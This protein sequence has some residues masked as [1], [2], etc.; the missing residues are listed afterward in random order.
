MANA[1]EGPKSKSTQVFRWK[2]QQAGR[3]RAEPRVNN[4][5]VSYLYQGEAY[6]VLEI[7]QEKLTWLS[8]DIPVLRIAW[9]GVD[10]KVQLELLDDLADLSA[11]TGVFLQRIHGKPNVQIKFK[12]GV[13]RKVVPVDLFLLGGSGDSELVPLGQIVS[14]EAQSIE[15]PAAFSSRP[16]IVLLFTSSKA[17][18]YRTALELLPISLE[19]PS[20]LVAPVSVEAKVVE[21]SPLVL[22]DKDLDFDISCSKGV[23]LLAFE[24]PSFFASETD[25]PVECEVTKSLHLRFNVDEWRRL[26]GRTLP[27]SGSISYRMSTGEVGKV[28]WQVK[29]YERWSWLDWAKFRVIPWLGLFL[30]GLSA[31]VIGCVVVTRRL[32]RRFD[33]V[34]GKVTSEIISRLSYISEAITS[35]SFSVGSIKS[36]LETWRRSQSPS[37]DETELRRGKLDLEQR[38]AQSRENEELSQQRVKVL[39]RNV[40]SLEQERQSLVEKYEAEFA[41]VNETRLNGEERIKQFAR[42]LEYYEKHVIFVSEDTTPLLDDLR[43]QMAEFVS[44]AVKLQRAFEEVVFTSSGSLLAIRQLAD[45]YI[46]S[47]PLDRVQTYITYIAELS[48]ERRSVFPDLVGRVGAGRKLSADDCRRKICELFYHS[49]IADRWDRVLRGLQRFYHIDKV[50]DLN[51]GDSEAHKQFVN[52]VKL[53]AAGAENALR[54]IDVVPLAISFLDRVGERVSPFV[55]Y[56]PEQPIEEYYPGW[57]ETRVDRR[58]LVLDAHSWGYLDSRGELWGRK[59]ARLVMSM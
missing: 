17:L 22:G 44:N 55:I 8:L 36:S 59:K 41:R 51:P 14:L 48:S 56:L 27:L 24:A 11:F 19:A 38:L 52:N 5:V 15:L 31:T 54:Q 26:P 58:G 57:K 47:F 37:E 28:P 32:S 53:Y 30:L 33:G 3:I 35:L 10:A 6:R 18:S 34:D 2:A 45:G 1:A 23:Q 42:E 20:S 16:K 49:C 46:G 21:I 7:R 13:P 50:I 40:Q 25:F 43:W 39:E 9:V 29:V 4:N 12:P